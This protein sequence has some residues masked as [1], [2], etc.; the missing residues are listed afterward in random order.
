MESIIANVCKEHNYLAG[1]DAVNPY[2]RDVFLRLCGQTGTESD[3]NGCLLTLTRM[4]HAHYGKHAILLIDEYDVPLAQANEEKECGERYYPQM[5]DVMR[6]I[7]GTALKSNEHLLFAVIT[8]CLRIAKDSVFAGV[9]NFA[10]YS[11][12]DEGFSPYFGFTQREVDDLLAATNQRGK[13]A[14]L[15]E[16]YDGYLFGNSAVYCPWDVVNYVA[17]LLKRE[18]AEP[19]NYWKSTSGNAIIRYFVGREDFQLTPKLEA[20][21]N[22][23]TIIQTV[24]D[25]LTYD[26]LHETEDKLWSV[27]TM[28]GYLTK[29]DPE[30]NGDTV[31][32]RIPNKEVEGIF[33]DAVIRHFSEQVDMA[34][35]THLM[36]ALWNGDVS[37]ASEA[38]S[39]FLWQT[40]S[41][42]DYHEDYYHAFLAGLFSGRGYCVDSNK[43]HGLGRPSV[44]LTDYKNRRAL[45]IEAKKSNSVER[46]DKDCDKALRQIVDQRYTKGL[47][48]YQVHC[49]GIAFFHKSAKVKKL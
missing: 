2:D 42:M 25:E 33:E 7:M 1:S 24:S 29:A 26:T 34:E 39:N 32:L 47:Q 21:M 13:A 31:K 6:N 35:F 27:L 23:G 45:I 43:G 12:L 46:M 3:V 40:I 22:G 14:A 48:A 20:L 9:N 5:L 49:Y 16:Y 8:G 44:M 11:V 19:K 15:K 38:L 41:Y 28:T 30:E 10:S 17:A 18:S 37:A 4:M 36:G